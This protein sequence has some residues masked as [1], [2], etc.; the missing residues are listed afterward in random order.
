MKKCASAIR[1]LGAV[2]LERYEQWMTG[3][4]YLDMT[5]YWHWRMQQSDRSSLAS[6]V[7]RIT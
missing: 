3:Y 7:S 6:A 4:R 2:L 5:S 1:L